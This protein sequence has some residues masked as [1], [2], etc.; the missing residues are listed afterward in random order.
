MKYIVFLF[1]V[2]FFDAT[3]LLM[4]KYQTHPASYLN[5]ILPAV[6]FTIVLKSRLPL[7]KKY[8]FPEFS[9]KLAKL[10]S[11]IANSTVSRKKC[12]TCGMAEGMRIIIETNIDKNLNSKSRKT[13]CRSHGL[14][15]I[16]KFLRTFKGIILLTEACPRQFSGWFFYRPEDLKVHNYSEEDKKILDKLIEGYRQE[17]GEG[18]LLWLNKEVIG[19]CVEAPLFKKLSDPEIITIDEAIKRLRRTLDQAQAKFKRSELWFS[20]PRGNAGIYLW[21]SEI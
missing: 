3:M 8:S 17:I 7:L 6:L 10:R 20:E 9:S 11:Q 12:C 21:T 1:W 2:I 13:Y 16:D 4:N 14:E 5:F 19:S 18:K 15:L